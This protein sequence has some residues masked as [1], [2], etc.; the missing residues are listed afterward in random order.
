MGGQG[1][2]P[3]VPKVLSLFCV[4]WRP[5]ILFLPFLLLFLQRPTLI[6]ED[7]GRRRRDVGE[8]G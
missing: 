4:F 2:A 8:E 1:E 6:L 5:L 7:S 3:K